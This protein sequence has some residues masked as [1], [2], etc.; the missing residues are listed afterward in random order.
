MLSN[1]TNQI[2]FR[3]H[4]KNLVLISLLIAMSIVFGKV[5][6]FTIGPLRISFEN[7]PILMAGIFLGAGAGAVTGVCADI[8]G[9]MIVGYEVNPIISLGA[10]SIGLVSGFVYRMRFPE[11]LKLPVSVMMAH[12]VGSML[13]KSIG[14]M[15]GLGYPVQSILLRIPLYIGIGIVELSVIIV[16]LKNHAFAL[17]IERIRKK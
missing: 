5:L 17:Q 11:K 6:A 9:C 14:L 12:I 10:M 16:L 15:I 7:L 13:I 2:G 8:V 3:F 1:K 4:V